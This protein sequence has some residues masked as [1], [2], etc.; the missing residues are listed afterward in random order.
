[1][2]SETILHR[3]INRSALSIPACLTTAVVGQSC[4]H[5]PPTIV[6][7]I[8]VVYSSRIAPEMNL[9]NSL[10]LLLS[11]PV[12]V[13]AQGW[14]DSHETDPPEPEWRLISTRI[15]CKGHVPHLSLAIDQRLKADRHSLHVVLQREAARLLAAMDVYAEAG[16][17]DDGCAAAESYLSRPDDVDEDMGFMLWMDIVLHKA[18]GGLTVGEVVEWERHMMG[19]HPPAGDRDDETE[20]EPKEILMEI[21]RDMQK[22]RDEL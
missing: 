8:E 3:E 14:E 12:V 5:T 19:R 9:L 6:L 7:H 15:T 18:G 17:G 11:L 20:R 22:L 1:M 10:F 13:T 21:V 16:E 4:R 2:I